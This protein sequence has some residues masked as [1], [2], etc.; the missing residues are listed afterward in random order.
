LPLFPPGVKSW[1]FIFNKMNNKKLLN[2]IRRK[3]VKGYDDFSNCYCIKIEDWN[4]IKQ[5]E[6]EL[7]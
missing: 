6:E 5:Q 7:K 4:E 2:K 3:M 1:R